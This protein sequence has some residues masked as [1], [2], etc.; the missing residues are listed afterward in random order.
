MSQAVEAGQGD[1]FDEEEQANEPTDITF[2]EHLHPARPRSLRFR[3]RVKSS[4]A[5]RSATQDG[6]AS[7]GNQAYV[8][9][10]LAQSMLSDA[11]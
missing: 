5:R 4:F 8:S 2:D 11:N 6:P 7:G 3:P 10:L 9:W 1:E